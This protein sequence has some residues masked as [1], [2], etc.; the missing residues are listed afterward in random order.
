LSAKKNFQR[1]PKLL[2]NIFPKPKVICRILS[3]VQGEVEVIQIGKERR[4]VVD[5]Y[6]QSVNFDC[7]G[8]GERV[9]GQI[10]RFA[11][12]ECPE[13]NIV[14]LLGLGGGTVAGLLLS[15]KPSLKICAVEIDPRIIEVAYKCFNLK[16][17]RNLEVL[18]GD[19][20]NFPKAAYDIIITDVYCGGGFPPKFWSGRFIDRVHKSLNEGGV[21]IFNRI[22]EIEPRDVIEKAKLCLCK[23]F[24]RVYYVCV[25]DFGGSGNVLFICRK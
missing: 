11:L 3:S 10:V 22:L 23:Y 20:Y 4:L 19:A 24:S 8:V 2:S 25:N 1:V 17:L 13:A 12:E 16:A 14:L 6:V 15:V 9:W 21:A 18:K 7:P 5:G